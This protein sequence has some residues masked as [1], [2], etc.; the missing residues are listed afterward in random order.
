MNLLLVIL[1]YLP[2]EKF[3]PVKCIVS[4]QSCLHYCSGYS[5]VFFRGKDLEGKKLPFFATGVSSVVHPVS[6]LSICLSVGMSLII[7]L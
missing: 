5:N 4:L 3:C 1:K 6:S 2:G 7:C